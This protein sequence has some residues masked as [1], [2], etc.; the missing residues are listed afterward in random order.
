VVFKPRLADCPEAFAHYVL[1]HELAHAYLRNGGWGDIADPE[2]TTHAIE[3]T[4][5]SAERISHRR[6]PKTHSTAPTCDS[7]APTVFTI[8][9]CASAILNR[10]PAIGF[11]S[12]KRI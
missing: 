2:A 8:P 5:H 9:N 10:G 7:S 6:E 3:G 1:A 4:I 12:S 11:C